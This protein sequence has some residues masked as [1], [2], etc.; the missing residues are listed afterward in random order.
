MTA[1]TW[2]DSSVRDVAH[3]FEVEAARVIDDVSACGTGGL[4]ASLDG[5]AR[6]QRCFWC[7]RIAAKG[8][9]LPGTGEAKERQRR[10][11][12]EARRYARQRGA[13]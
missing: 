11:D 3:A 4:A 1:Y 8:Q 7:A 10:R 9:S 5:E 2:R 12:A 13:G 6:H